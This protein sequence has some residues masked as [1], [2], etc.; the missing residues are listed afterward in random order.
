MARHIARWGTPSSVSSWKNNV[1]TLRDML[2]V[3][4]GY[5]K[6]HL[7]S[8]FGLSDAEYAQLFPNG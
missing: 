5:V 3:R 4:A 7:K 1:D 2:K 6:K 8:Y